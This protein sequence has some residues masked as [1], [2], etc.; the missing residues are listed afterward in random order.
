MHFYKGRTNEGKVD[1]YSKFCARN[2]T[3]RWSREDH[4]RS[5]RWFRRSRSWRWKTKRLWTVYQ[6]PVAVQYC[7][8][9]TGATGLNETG[10]LCTRR[11]HTQNENAIRSCTHLDFDV[12]PIAQNDELKCTFHVRIHLSVSTFVKRWLIHYL[13]HRFIRCNYIK[14]KT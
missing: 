9:Y 4:A 2:S 3:R 11:T 1:P 8:R 7:R 14:Y 5:A 12:A 13:T 6:D 10:F